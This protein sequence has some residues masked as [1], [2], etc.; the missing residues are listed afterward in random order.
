MKRF[1]IAAAAGTALLLGGCATTVR[2]HVTTFQQWPATLPDKTYVFDAPAPQDDTLE[3]R[4]Y[5]NLVRGELN[6]LG[7]HDAGAAGTPTLA[8]S[9]RVMTTDIPVRV[10]EVV[11]ASY[12][13]YYGWGRSHHFGMWGGWYDPFWYGPYLDHIEHEYRRDLQVGIRSLPDNR[14]LFDVTV[15]NLSRNESTPAI[16]PA[17]VHSAFAD[18][19]GPNGQARVVEVKLGEKQ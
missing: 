4:A 5:Q 16:M 14:R 9:M 10:V 19:P 7:F 13:G 8:V 2:S 11:P 17:L 3:F 12:Y 6:A 15:R 18:F 1:L